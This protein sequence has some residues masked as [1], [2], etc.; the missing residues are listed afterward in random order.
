MT[1]GSAI[2]VLSEILVR[3]VC[4]CIDASQRSIRSHEMRGPRNILRKYYKV[5]MR[6][7][8]V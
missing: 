2:P 1:Q 3:K 7:T 6:S 5:V 4:V 8:M